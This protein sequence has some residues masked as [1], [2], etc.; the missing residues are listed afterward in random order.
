MITMNITKI[1]QAN[2]ARLT[3]IYNNVQQAKAEKEKLG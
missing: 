2:H 3:E 1:L